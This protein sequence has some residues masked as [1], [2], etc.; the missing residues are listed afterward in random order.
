MSDEQELVAAVRARTEGTPYV[1][2]ETDT[3]F[4]VQIDVEDA[5]W[6]AVAYK[7]HLSKT[8]VYRVKFEKGD[9]TLSITDDVRDVQWRAGV[10]ASGGVPTPVLSVSKS[11]D[12]GRFEVK[13]FRKTY[14]VDEQ[15]HYGKV[16][17]FHFTSSEGRDL[18]R[19]PA[20]EL[21]WTERRGGY[22][23]IGLY[24]AVGTLALLVL[25]GIAVA[26]VALT[27]GL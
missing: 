25:C 9:K 5:S 17:D 14:A 20:R 1:L 18:I 10:A 3:G 23:R 19:G 11:G 13:S 26:V 6:Y 15:G 16:V 2:T 27:T 8:W 24:V 21:G 22:E 4:D 12:K 7:Q